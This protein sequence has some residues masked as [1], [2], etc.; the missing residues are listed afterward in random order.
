MDFNTLH[1][2]QSTK[3]WSLENDESEDD[4]AVK[5]D[6]EK[7]KEEDGEEETEVRLRNLVLGII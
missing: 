6:S 5:S 7:K 4:E 1:V 3:I 2:S